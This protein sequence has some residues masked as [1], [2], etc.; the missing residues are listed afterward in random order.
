M[1]AFNAQINQSPEKIMIIAVN[2]VG[3][4]EKCA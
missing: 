3:N 2:S 4:V 1:L